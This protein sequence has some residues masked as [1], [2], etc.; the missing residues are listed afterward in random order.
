M[1]RMFSSLPPSRFPPL[2]GLSAELTPGDGDARFH[3]AVDAMLDGMV[4]R[5]GRR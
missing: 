5:A 2:A 3:F 4:A 1:R